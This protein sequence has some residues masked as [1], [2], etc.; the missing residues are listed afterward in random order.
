M[1][2]QTKKDQ[3]EFCKRCRN[4][5]RLKNYK[6]RETRSKSGYCTNCGNKL[7]KMIKF[8]KTKYGIIMTNGIGETR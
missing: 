1:P 5:L 6:T 8:T 2:K 3:S 7:R 4:H